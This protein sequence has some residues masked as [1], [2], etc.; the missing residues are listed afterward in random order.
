MRNIT[1]SCRN[2]AKG[3]GNGDGKG[4]SNTTTGTLLSPVSLKEQQLTHPT[5]PKTPLMPTVTLLTMRDVEGSLIAGLL[6]EACQCIW[7][8]RSQQTEGP[9]VLWN[10]CE[11]CHFGRGC[12]TFR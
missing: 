5:V 2:I 4:S 3:T 9:D 10:H 7:Y 6:W 12:R 8:Q 11:R 1:N